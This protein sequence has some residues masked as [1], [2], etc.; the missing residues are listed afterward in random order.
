MLYFEKNLKE[1]EAIT[2]VDIST[3]T[4]YLDAHRVARAKFRSLGAVTT[5]HGVPR[6]RCMDLDLEERDV[7]IAL[8]KIPQIGRLV[9][10]F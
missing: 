6:A 2:N 10:V 5:D 1:F 3:F 9:R 7:V 8:E 4:G